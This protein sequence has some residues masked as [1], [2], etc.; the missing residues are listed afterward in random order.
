MLSGGELAATWHCVKAPRA[1]R[2]AEDVTRSN[3]VFFT[4]PAYDA[5]LAAP[6]G[7]TVE[8]IGDITLELNSTFGQS[9]EVRNVK[10]EFFSR[11]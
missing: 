6:P 2:E 5:V 3:Y 9:S 11:L 1:S 10:L 7:A 8:D 4:Q